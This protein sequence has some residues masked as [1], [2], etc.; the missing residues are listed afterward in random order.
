MVG[1]REDTIITWILKTVALSTE[2]E[3]II[4]DYSGGL[5]IPIMKWDG[6]H[7]YIPVQ[8]FLF[9]SLSSCT[10][11]ILDACITLDLCIHCYALSPYHN[12]LRPKLLGQGVFH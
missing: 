7:V 8:S 11:R 6:R 10:P 2:R 12:R 1:V 3:M 5:S 4:R 9:N